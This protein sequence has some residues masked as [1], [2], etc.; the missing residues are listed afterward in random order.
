MP[1]LLLLLLLSCCRTI[2][3]QSP[4]FL[5]ALT[6]AASI[7]LEHKRDPA[8]YVQ[9]YSQL[10]EQHG[11]Y[12]SYRLLGAALLR[13]QEPE[14]AIRVSICIHPLLPA[15]CAIRVCLTIKIKQKRNKIKLNFFLIKKVQPM[16]LKKA[17][18]ATL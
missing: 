3:R 13:I 6:A 10:A 5:K 14:R 9:C 4:H 18:K 1:A 16:E 7:Q 8:A 11:D 17:Q 12:E 15:F 2:D